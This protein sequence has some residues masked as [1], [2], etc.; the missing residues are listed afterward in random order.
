MN[1]FII[2]GIVLI[3]I[4]MILY[5]PYIRA[6]IDGGTFIE[7]NMDILSKYISGANIINTASDESTVDTFKIPFDGNIINATLNVRKIIIL[8]VYSDKKTLSFPMTRNILK[9]IFIL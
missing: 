3:I 2:I 9:T 1:K 7:N 5:I 8:I 6:D 4:G